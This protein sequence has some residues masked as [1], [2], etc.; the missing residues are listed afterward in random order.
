MIVTNIIVVAILQRSCIYNTYT[1][2]S[3]YLS[4]YISYVNTYVYIYICI[5]IHVWMYGCMSLSLSL[6][7]YIYIYCTHGELSHPKRGVARY[8]VVLHP[9]HMFRWEL[10]EQD[11]PNRGCRGSSFFLGYDMTCNN[12]NSYNYYYYYYYNNYY[13]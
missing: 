1:S 11:L 10:P 12:T 5:C 13:Y 2:L 3:L 8:T 4:L 7:I 9:S 6:S